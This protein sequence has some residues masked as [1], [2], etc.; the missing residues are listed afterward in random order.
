MGHRDERPLGKSLTVIPTPRPFLNDQDALLALLPGYHD[1]SS[2]SQPKPS[3]S[4]SRPLPPPNDIPKPPYKDLLL[5]VIVQQTRIY[6]LESVLRDSQDLVKDMRDCLNEKSTTLHRIQDRY[7]TLETTMNDKI[8]ETGAILRDLA[9]ELK[10]SHEV[11]KRLNGALQRAEK[12]KTGA[13]DL[14]QQQDVYVSSL[15]DMVL[16]LRTLDGKQRDSDPTVLAANLRRTAMV[17]YFDRIKLEDQK[18]RDEL[19]AITSEIDT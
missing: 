1:P 7:T 18:Y 19:N 14:L 17:H 4:K 16:E 9:T 15:E 12:R 6:G 2:P 3:S 11:E 10:R 13:E 8:I 5:W